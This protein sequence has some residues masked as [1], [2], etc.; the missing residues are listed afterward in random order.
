MI[1]GLG[2]EFLHGFFYRFIGDFFILLC[3]FLFA[4][5][6]WAAFTMTVFFLKT[7]DLNS[8]GDSE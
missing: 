1:F 6:R 4:G 7:L 8:F 2:G 3:G 5:F